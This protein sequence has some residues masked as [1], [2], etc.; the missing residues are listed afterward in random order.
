MHRGG[1][2]VSLVIGPGLVVA[3]VR[4]VFSEEDAFALVDAS[5]SSA[6]PNVVVVVVFD[7]WPV[8]TRRRRSHELRAHVPWLREHATL[9]VVCRDPIAAWAIRT[10]AT[11]TRHHA[12]ERRA[13]ICGS[14][15]AALAAL[16]EMPASTPLLD[17][18]VRLR[19]VELGVEVP[20]GVRT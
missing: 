15:D 3:R 18:M 8:P 1:V 12:G 17:A 14:V 2:S 10:I 20:T 4:G 16:A 13:E 11:V 6:A 5:L 7:G 19:L 9:L